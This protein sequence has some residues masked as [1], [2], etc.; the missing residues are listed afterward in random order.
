M[1]GPCA[2]CG[3]LVFFLDARHPQNLQSIKEELYLAAENR[4][5]LIVSVLAIIICFAL[6]V[7]PLALSVKQ[8]LDLQGGTHVVLQAEDTPEA[9]VDDDAMNRSISIIERRVNELG[10][11]EPVIQ[12]QGRDRII[13]EL[14]GVKDPE[15]A[16]AMLGKRLCL[17]SRTW[18][19]IRS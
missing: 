19:A 6:L 5:K 7:K 17:N 1:K 14:P 12:R 11:T 18:K 10:L 9:K 16:I 13:V 8:G 4:I 3:S 15:Q 2:F